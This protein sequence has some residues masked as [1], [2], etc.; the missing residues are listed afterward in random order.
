MKH[1]ELIVKSA[2]AIK[3][4]ISFSLLVVSFVLIVCA[5]ILQV[6]DLVRN[7]GPFMELFLTC[8]GLY[9]GRSYVKSKNIKQESKE[10]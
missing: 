1:K 10:E 3:K 6:F 5:G 7:T 8:V 2:S 4:E 9:F